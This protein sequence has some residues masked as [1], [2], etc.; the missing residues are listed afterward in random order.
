M[1]RTHRKGRR[2]SN[3]KYTQ[4]FEESN[5]SNNRNI[6]LYIIPAVIILM[7]AGSTVSGIL[8]LQQL[9]P[10]YDTKEE[11]NIKISGLAW[12]FIEDP[13]INVLIIP[14]PNLSGWKD[15]NIDAVIEA[16]DEW[17]NCIELFTHE[18][19][20]DYLESIRFKIY[21]S[22]E[23]IVEKDDYDITVNWTNQIDSKG[24]AGAA[25]MLSNSDR[26]ITKATI[27]LPISVI[28]DEKSYILSDNDLTNIATD[29]IGHTLGLG[30]S[31]FKGDVLHGFYNFPQEEY[32]HS[33]LDIY[34]LSMIYQYL[35][36]DLF[37]SPDK[38][39][40][41]LAETGITY[42]HLQEHI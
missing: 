3:T 32:C 17:I 16:F 10:F 13:V 40:I 19:G 33:T 28:K 18:Y 42:H 11:Y 20:Y 23:N 24:A 4:D 8:P 7:I 37:E 14:N 15:S 2:T 6:K 39:T 35:E 21:V 29:E 36:N 9:N 22:S 12:D 26:R 5:K 27:T 41:N 30:H 1:L 25:I 34:G 31:N 38:S